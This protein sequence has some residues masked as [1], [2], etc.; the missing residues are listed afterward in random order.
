MIAF[1][2]GVIAASTR[3]GSM[4]P[5]AASTSTSTGVAPAWTTAWRWR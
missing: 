1:V 5:V 2:A 3:A 4:L